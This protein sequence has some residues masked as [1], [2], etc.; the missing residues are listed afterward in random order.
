MK[1]SLKT[2]LALLLALAMVFSL[3]ACGGGG[4][5]DGGGDAEPAGEGDASPYADVEREPR[6]L[7]WASGGST[8]QGY[9]TG[10][11]MAGLLPNVYDGYT[12]IPEV[13]TGGVG[14]GKMLLDGLGDFISM[15]SDDA[16]AFNHNERD[17][18][19]IPECTD[20]LRM[21]CVFSD[22]ILNIIARG[23]DDSIQSFEDLK[24]KRLAV[25]S[26]STKTYAF[27]YLL[28]SHGMTEADF[29]DLHDMARVDMVT[30]MQN[31]TVDC[32]IDMIAF[33]NSSYTE[34]ANALPGGIKFVSLSDDEVKAMQELNGSYLPC[35]VPADTYK[36]VKDAQTI[37]LYNLYLTYKEMPD[38]VVYD[39]L[40]CMYDNNDELKAAH[41]KAGMSM[42]QDAFNDHIKMFELH[43]G[44]EAFYKELGWL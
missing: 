6:E 39:V 7:H 3:A 20:R 40:K 12:V 13:T 8:G 25:L 34:L 15:Q 24:G 18:V 42:D 31:G 19:D 11:V 29:A 9:I 32:V 17:W 33:G 4:S 43:P 16:Y 23:D 21:V 35:Q 14:N 38:Y 28:D 10:S 22:T 2:L 36:G 1:K 27:Q 41:P 44:A 5:A 30:E 37:M 26:G